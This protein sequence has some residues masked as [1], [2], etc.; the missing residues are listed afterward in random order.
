MN[1][2]TINITT[3]AKPAEKSSS[4]KIHKGDDDKSNDNVIQSTATSTVEIE[5]NNFK[6][7]KSKSKIT[8]TIDNIYTRDSN[9]I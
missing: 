7:C 6:K 9:C 8:E 1:T 5:E 4:N 2:A 3:A